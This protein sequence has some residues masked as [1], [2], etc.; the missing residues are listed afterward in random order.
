MGTGYAIPNFPIVGENKQSPNFAHVFGNET[1]TI[2][3]GKLGI[4]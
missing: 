2:N 3:L 4:A 1:A